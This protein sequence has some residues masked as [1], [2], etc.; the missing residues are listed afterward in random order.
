MKTPYDTALR[1]QQREVDAVK[2]AIAAAV[3]RV[4]SLE[5]EASALQ[6]RTREERVLAHALPFDSDAWLALAKRELARLAAE[7]EAARGRLVQLRAQALEAFGRLRAIEIAAERYRDEQ[8]RA[9]EAAEQAA[10]DDIAAARFLRERK[11]MLVKAG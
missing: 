6:G 8:A 10:I 11:R 4:A 1:M 2:V 7:A 9:L 3:E 5:E